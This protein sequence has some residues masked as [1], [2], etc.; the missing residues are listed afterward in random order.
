MT[1]IGF[2]LQLRSIKAC[3]AAIYILWGVQCIVLLLYCIAIIGL[4]LNVYASC[5]Y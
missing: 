1:V 4:Q 2:E 5:Y 3:I